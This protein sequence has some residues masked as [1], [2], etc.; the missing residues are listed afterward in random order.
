MR[1]T[2]RVA[3]SAANLETFSESF[4]SC[5]ALAVTRS[6][7]S[8]VFRDPASHLSRHWTNSSNH[9]RYSASSVVTG[10]ASQER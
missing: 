3:T 10:P 9:F 2:F 7:S 8:C 6:E 4:A 5:S 1:S